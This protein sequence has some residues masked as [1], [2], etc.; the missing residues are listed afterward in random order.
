[1]KIFEEHCSRCG[2]VNKQE[3]HITTSVTGL[4]FNCE[5]DL[6]DT[7][8][9]VVNEISYNDKKEICKKHGVSDIRKAYVAKKYGKSI[10]NVTLACDWCGAMI[11]GRI[12]EK[13][14]IYYDQEALC[15]GCQRK[16]ERNLERDKRE[17]KKTKRKFGF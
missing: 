7:L 1:M 8:N 3:K 16:Y 10:V 5:R 4:C 15:S 13:E 12:E 6:E 11:Q 14:G 17:R 2:K 9:K